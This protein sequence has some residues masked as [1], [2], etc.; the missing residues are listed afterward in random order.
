MNKKKNKKIWFLV[1]VYIILIV[2]ELFYFVPYHSIQ[3]FRTQQYK[4][5]TEIVGSGYASMDDIRWDKVND[6]KN[7]YT[8]RVGKIVNTPQLIINVSLTTLL[9]A[10]IFFLLQKNEK[11]KRMP[12]MEIPVIDVNALAFAAEDD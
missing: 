8:S 6:W 3:I 11:V 4:P 10:A 7:G 12:E 2:T 5:Y 1:I 9:A